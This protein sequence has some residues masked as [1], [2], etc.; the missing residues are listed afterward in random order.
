M[1]RAVLFLAA[2]GLAACHVEYHAA[3]TGADS[4]RAVAALAAARAESVAAFRRANTRVDTVV[5]VDTVYVR[6]TIPALGDPPADSLTLGPAV[7]AP[8]RR[9]T[10]ASTPAAGTPA[11]PS[12]SA[13]NASAAPAVVTD[14]DLAAL[15]ARG[16]RVPV[17]SVRAAD[18]PD[19]FNERRSGGTRPHE[20]LDILAARGTPVLSAD[21]G[22]IIKRFTSKAGGLTVY[23]LGPG[24]RLMAYY[25]HLDRYA[26]GLA[27]GAAV[28]RGDVLGTVG[29]TGDADASA[30]HLHFAL[31]VVSD[32]R[33]WWAGTPID[34]KPYLR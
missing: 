12:N 18:I 2:T 28:R 6:D 1:R 13:P 26:P 3:K 9:S 4:A 17:E 34:P 24:G 33:R 8:T 27:E 21:D 31:A 29:S 25:A 14:A 30:P 19:T 11:A 22:R 20:A 15:R 7:S 32:P 16:L 23:V 5:R 10:V